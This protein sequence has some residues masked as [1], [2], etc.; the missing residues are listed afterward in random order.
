VHQNVRY[1]RICVA[2]RLSYR[3]RN[4]VTFANTQCGIH[5]HVEI[6]VE[7]ESHFAHAALVEGADAVHGRGEIAH[8]FLHDLGWR[9]I[10]HFMQGW[11]KK[12]QPV[13]CDNAAR[14]QSSPI[15][16]GRSFKP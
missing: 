8:L 10:H 12:V 5:S 14:R 3:V 16:R 7:L 13:P 6:D 2:D 15:V 1:T 9:R 11:A 4:A